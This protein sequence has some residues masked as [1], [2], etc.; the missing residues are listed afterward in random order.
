M[1]EDLISIGVVIAPAASADSILPTTTTNPATIMNLPQIHDVEVGPF[2][3]LRFQPNTINATVGEIVRF[4]FRAFNHTLTQ[5]SLEQPCVSSN[6]FDSG[7]RQFNAANT[8]NMIVSFSINS[9]EPQFF[10]CHQTEPVSHCDASMVFA[11]NPGLKMDQFLSNAALRT[12]SFATSLSTSSTATASLPRVP[13]PS[14]FSSTTTNPTASI[15]IVLVSTVLATVTNSASGT[16]RFPIM[17]GNVGGISF[18]GPAGTGIGTATGSRIGMAT[19]T[20]ASSYLRTGAVVRSEPQV[21]ATANSAVS[22]S[23]Y[24]ALALAPSVWLLMTYSL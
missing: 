16:A 23:A 5:S 18:S 11:I 6:Q 4:T 12:A 20:S 22:I 2:G 13:A 15:P 8:S 7:F 3:Q 1:N 24:I 14:D 17:S 19:G 9:P 10:Y 21:I